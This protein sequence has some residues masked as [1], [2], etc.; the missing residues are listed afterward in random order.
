[1]DYSPV[2][3]IPGFAKRAPSDKK[4]KSVE[5]YTIRIPRENTYFKCRRNRCFRAGAGMITYNL[6]HEE[7]AGTGFPVIKPLSKKGRAVND[8]LWIRL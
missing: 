7:E 1:M 3:Y 4:Q 8:T 6:L 5:G 2:F